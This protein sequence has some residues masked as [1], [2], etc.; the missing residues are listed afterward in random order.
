[1]IKLYRGS[2]FDAKCDL[3]IV[4]CNNKGGMASGVYH[5]IVQNNL[6]FF[7]INVEPGDVKFIEANNSFSNASYIGYAASVD[8]NSNRSNETILK[9]IMLAIKAFC[10][11]QSIKKVNIP[12]LG[13][14]AG[15]VSDYDSYR[16]ICNEFAKDENIDVDIYAF[17]AIKYNNLISE[18]KLESIPKIK[19]PRVFIS[20]TATNFE[21]RN[22]VKQLAIQ[23]RQNGVE[24]RIDIFHLKPGQDLPQWM[25]NEIIMADKVLLICDKNYSNKSDNRKG[26]VGWESMIIQGD[27]LYRQ[28]QVKY[29]SLLRDSDIDRSLPIYVKSKYALDW[30]NDNAI[31]EKF[32][33]LL[34]CLFDCDLE[35]PLGNIPQHILE[36]LRLK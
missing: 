7:P 23:L 14:G 9:K 5:K 10:M 33:E 19:H 31:E 11:E 17:S 8:A 34:L 28:D 20:Y 16:A 35:P 12:L 29:I 25:A 3:I 22:W 15:R 36:K 30:T 6:P 18:K 32:E 13:T 27:M 1:M 26:G 24:A 4:P 21:E 2:I